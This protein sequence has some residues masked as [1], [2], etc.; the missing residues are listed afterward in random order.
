MNDIDLNTLSFDELKQQADVLDVKYSG[1]IGEEGLRKRIR[2]ALGE[3]V[4]AKPKAP[5]GKKTVFVTIA[6]D[7]DNKQPVPLGLNGK[8]IR[9]RRG[10]RVEIPEAFLAVLQNAVRQEKDP[11]SGELIETPAYPYS[12][13][14]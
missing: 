4:E 11:E 10:E 1:N 5:T 14:R 3:E 7:K 8:I 9:I 13:E 12:V 6:K 2:E